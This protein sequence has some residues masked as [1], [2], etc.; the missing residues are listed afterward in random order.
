MTRPQNKKDK[1]NNNSVLY[2]V[3]GIF[4]YGVDAKL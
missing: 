3:K 4:E 2:E 1:R